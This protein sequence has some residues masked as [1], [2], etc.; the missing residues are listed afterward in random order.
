MTDRQTDGQTDGQTD[1]RGKIICLL[2][3]KGG[4]IISTHVKS[5]ISLTGTVKISPLKRSN[6]IYNILEAQICPPPFSPANLK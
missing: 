6:L 3:L 1:A 5:S 4:D 2:T